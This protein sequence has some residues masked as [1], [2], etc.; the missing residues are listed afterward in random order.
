M[1]HTQLFLEGWFLFI[2][3][4]ESLATPLVYFC[5]KQDNECLG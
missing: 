5:R 4:L 2:I 3:V 1:H